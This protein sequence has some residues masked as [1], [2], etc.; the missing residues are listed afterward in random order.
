MFRLNIFRLV[1]KI[2]YEL[3]VGRLLTQKG[4]KFECLVSLVIL[5]L[6]KQDSD[7]FNVVLLLQKPH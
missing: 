1:R 7:N 2:I 6:Q 5:L 4:W 3:K